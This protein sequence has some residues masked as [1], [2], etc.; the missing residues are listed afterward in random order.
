MKVDKEWKRL[1]EDGYKEKEKEKKYIVMINT[2]T[3]CQT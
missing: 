1:S 3:V 2:N